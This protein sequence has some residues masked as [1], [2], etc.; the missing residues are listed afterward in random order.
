LGD[1]VL[2]CV[3]AQD[4]SKPADRS[5][6][7]RLAARHG[8]VLPER[9]A[10]TAERAEVMVNTVLGGPVGDAVRA[11]RTVMRETPFVL[12]IGGALV[13]GTIDLLYQS[14]DG[15]WALVDY[16][17]DRVA[18]SA[19][20][21]VASGYEMQLII[22]SAAACEFLRT[23]IKHTC[24][25]FTAPGIIHRLEVR[26]S[27]RDEVEHLLKDIRHGL[28]TNRPECAAK[29]TYRALCERSATQ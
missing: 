23:T 11:A 22:Y 6:I 24:L 5:L 7:D 2:G 14:A 29:C 12:G 18:A 8:V 13:S 27:A 9:R 28:R 4:F 16:K 20:E 19:V 1:I 25:V 21:S 17:T 26:A 10:A 15:E 3:G